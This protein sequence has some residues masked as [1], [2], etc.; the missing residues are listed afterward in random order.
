V[1]NDPANDVYVIFS[2]DAEPALQL[3]LFYLSSPLTKGGS[4]TAKIR[5]WAAPPLTGGPWAASG[6]AVTVYDSSSLGPAPQGT[7]ATKHSGVCWLNPDSGRF[8]IITLTNTPGGTLV[9][10]RLYENLDYGEFAD[11]ILLEWDVV[12]LEWVP[13]ATHI[14]VWDSCH[15]G[16]RI[17]QYDGWAQLDPNSG[18]YEVVSLSRPALPLNVYYSVENDFTANTELIV[19]SVMHSWDGPS[20]DSGRVAKPK[21]VIVH[22]VE[23]LDD[24][25][26][27]YV[28]KGKTNSM[29]YAKYNPDSGRYENVWTECPDGAIDEPSSPGYNQ[30]PP[31]GGGT[32][33]WTL[34]VAVAPG[35]G[36]PFV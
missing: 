24:S 4:A 13:S 27:K 23:R 30:E 11:A 1:D 20:Y 21:E 25:K 6:G 18:N 9:P 26:G 5:T 28:F 12:D 33:E 14:T 19:G 22:N 17:A 36:A 29:G 10:F 32:G 15:V 35:A 7:D 16:P 31:P 3:Y 34:P 8:E 2:L